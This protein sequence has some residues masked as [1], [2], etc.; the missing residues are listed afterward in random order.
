[1]KKFREEFYFG[2]LDNKKREIESRSNNF[3]GQILFFAISLVVGCGGYL[4]YN[5][6]EPARKYEA[7]IEESK[8][9]K[10]DNLDIRVFDKNHFLSCENLNGI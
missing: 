7:E 2:E 8:A 10:K 6:L 9:L 3:Y 5:F 1:M 4:F